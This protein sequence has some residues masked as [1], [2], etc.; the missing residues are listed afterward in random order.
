MS[1]I[2]PSTPGRERRRRLGVSLALLAL[3]GCVNQ[4]SWAPTV[5]PYNDPNAARISQDEAECRQL[6]KQA[7]GGSLRK[8]AEGVGIGGAIGAGLGAALGA[9][10]GT[11]GEGA[12]LGATMGAATGGAKEG[13][14]S[15]RDF[16][17]AFDQCMR[18]RGHKVL[19][20]APSKTHAG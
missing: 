9:I 13:A 4:N 5:D 1:R 18:G 10:V 7:S 17:S 20:R 8:T 2:L 3:F 12:A 19:S 16:K 15:N 11:P 14:E 6:A